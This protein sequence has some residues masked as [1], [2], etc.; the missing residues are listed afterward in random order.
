[1]G[2]TASIAAKRGVR[3]GP[4]AGLSVVLTV[5]ASVTGAQESGDP[6]SDSA[7]LDPIT[8]RGEKAERSLQDTQTSAVVFDR[9]RIEREVA[10]DLD[11]IFLRIPNVNASA[12]TSS[13]AI[14]GISRNGV[15]NTGT[16]VTSNIFVDGAPLATFGLSFG[17]QSLWDVDR[18]EVLRGPQSTVQGR[19]SLAG[20]IY[21]ETADPT[22]D[23][24][25]RGR[26]R[27][28]ELGGRQYS[29]VLSGPLVDRQLAMRMAVDYQ[30]DDGQVNNA[31]TGEDSDFQDV[32]TFNGKLLWEPGA[33]PGLRATLIG[34]YAETDRG[35]FSLNPP[36]PF[37]SPE[38]EAWRP[39]RSPDFSPPQDNRTDNYRLIGDL[40]YD[41]SDALTLRSITTFEDIERSGVVG[42]ATDPTRF[43][44]TAISL[45][46]VE[47]VSTELRLNVDTGRFTGL[48]GLY[49][50]EEDNRNN[51]NVLTNL[52]RQVLFPI[53][54]PESIVDA[55]LFTD[56]TTENFAVF[57]EG[58]YDLSERWAVSFG[59]RFDTEEFETTETDQLSVDPATCLATIPQPT[60]DGVVFIDVPCQA[61]LPN[62]DEPPQSVDFD[63]FAPRGSL[64]YRF[65]RDRSIS[66]SVQRGFRAGGSFVIADAATG[67]AV[68]GTFDPE[69]LVNYELALRSRWFDRRLTVNANVF[70][71]DWND[72]Q[73]SIPGPSGS[74]FDT[75]IVNAGESELYGAE[76]TLD[77]FLG[78]GFSAF[79]SF[80]YL[81]T[82]FT[83]FPF[84]VVNLDGNEF[85]NAPEFSFSGGFSWES[86]NG[87]FIDANVNH[88]AGQFSTVDNLA[89]NSV[90]SFT[91]VNGRA[92]YRNARFSL[93]AFANN[94]LDE[95]FLTRA[96]F[97]SVVPGTGE[98]NTLD[99]GSVNLGR[100][101][102]AGVALEF[103]F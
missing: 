6:D 74:Q 88:T 38:F 97:R 19:N 17:L 67:E 22:Y 76:L 63:A 15:G 26:L 60:P 81:H 4:T 94:L 43:D 47:T 100:P 101:R 35:D 40:A 58:R 62:S 30:L 36:G 5:L 56:I 16:G 83:D 41:L 7:R 45:N 96:N 28:A 61:L 46:E 34:N 95:N 20:A 64:I 25:S 86:F 8:V 84:G 59:A 49:Y 52:Q 21:I 68:V 102:V 69:F 72:Q 99:P 29:A 1:M 44:E 51:L 3:R 57:G 66:F 2:S 37:G 31:I 13:V 75:R 14:R 23:W 54:P 10:F 78:S 50:F 39:F 18:V 12:F 9:E 103:G 87:W 73:V 53:N 98:I 55:R 70:F 90:G 82:E 93:Y 48:V 24:E 71:S 92:G 89:I 80:G 85:P 42:S 79:A 11:D 32:L 33:L 91:L 27:F 65:D 77:A